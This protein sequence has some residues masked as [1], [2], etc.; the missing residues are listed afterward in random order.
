[1]T[2]EQIRSEQAESRK[3]SQ[4]TFGEG[5]HPP[6]PP[7][8]DTY[9]RE[10]ERRLRRAWFALGGAGLALV[11]SVWLV[12]TVSPGG[13]AWPFILLLGYVVYMRV[14]GRLELICP[15]CG[16]LFHGQRWRREACQHCGLK[17]GQRD[18]GSSRPGST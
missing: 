15:R 16:R 17:H 5:A 4:L 2:G 11:G 18:D 14:A 12:E 3:R 6:V 10:N 13:R 1:V 9:F 7:P 8:W